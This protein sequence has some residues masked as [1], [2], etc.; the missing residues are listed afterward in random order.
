MNKIGRNEPCPCGSGKKYKKCCGNRTPAARTGGPPPEVIQKI[1]KHFKEQE[2]QEQERVKRFGHVLP[3]MAIDAW[4]KKIIGVGNKL[5]WK[6]SD[7]CKYVPDFLRDYVPTLFG[8]EWHEEQSAKPPD[9]WHPLL[10]WRVKALSY[11]SKQPQMPDGSNAGLPSG[12]VAAYFTFGW[13]L[14]TV[15]QNSR[16][17]ARLLER[18]KN[19]EQ[20]QGAR[21]ELFA[22]ATCLRAGFQIEH[23]DEQDATRKHAEFTAT[24]KAT[25]QKISVEAKSKHRMGVLGRAGTLQ[26]ANELSLRFGELLNKAAQKN[27]LHP[28]VVFLDTNLPA[29]AAD[30]LFASTSTDD[31]FVPQPQFDTMFAKIQRAY[32][33]DPFSLVV[34]TNHP[35]HYTTEEEV[36]PRKHLLTVRFNAPLNRVV[37]AEAL[38]ALH[39]AAALYGNIPNEFPAP[40]NQLTTR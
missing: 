5:Y 36:D 8:S 3:I 28:L 27:P 22:E 19:H 32:G 21:H 40:Q 33:G 7:R 39:E 12:F 38:A 34:F 17:D 10:Q 35:H 30:R 2:I 1:V 13:D 20:F 31:P 29:S 24:Q 15:E 16:L 23:E 18:L 4:G 26:S 9:E 11:M 37:H 25:G 6:P 14:F